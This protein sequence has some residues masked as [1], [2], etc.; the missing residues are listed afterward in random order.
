M[1]FRKWK[2]SK[3]AVNE[4]IKKMDEINNFCYENGIIQSHNQDSYYFIINGHQYRVS[5]H[6]IESSNQG[7]FDQLTGQ[8]LRP[9]YHDKERDAS[10]IYIHASKTRLIDIYN[11]LKAGYKLDGRGYRIN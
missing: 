4:F 5:N 7:A 10:I 6:S 11:D 8:Q 2:P 1:S 3:K 9:L